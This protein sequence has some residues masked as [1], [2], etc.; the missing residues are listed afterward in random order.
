MRVMDGLH[1]V[2]AAILRG[3]E[4][5]EIELFDG[6]ERDALVQ[7]VKLNAKHG[8]P[9]SQEDR[10]GAA[11]RILAEFPDWSDRTIAE[12]IGISAK[13]VSELRKST[14][15]E[16]EAN[17]RVG[18]DGRV[19]PLSTT[20]GRNTAAQ[21]FAE[22]PG[23]S[24]R[25]VA[26]EAGISAGT[27]RDVRA[28]LSRGESPATPSE[29][30]ARRRFRPSAPTPQAPE[31]SR[32]EFRK[33]LGV[34]MRDPSMRLSENGRKV[35]RL[36]EAHLLSDADWS[37]LVEGVPTYAIDVLAQTA[38]GCAERWSWFAETLARRDDA[39]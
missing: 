26:R 7:A 28:R 24:L 13:R 10:I 34:L 14:E 8:L 25:E 2:R 21:L 17:V 20:E 4:L 15:G 19:R 9:L 3:E 18:K 27:A 11:G 1:R 37:V 38:R 6:T 30:G 29:R 31:L 35:L 32:E 36:L 16:L 39:I 5:I 22:R 33:V 12:L 23:A